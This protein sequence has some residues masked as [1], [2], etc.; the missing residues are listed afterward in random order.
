MGDMESYIVEQPR[1]AVMLSGT[2]D[3]VKKL[4]TSEYNGLFS[5]L[6][7]YNIPK[8]FNEYVTGRQQIDL[9]GDL[10]KDLQLAVLETADLW[11]GK[12]IEMKFSEEQETD[13]FDAMQDKKAMEEKYGGDIGA[14]W[15][16]MAL[17]TKR[18]AVTLAGFQGEAAGI[19]P[20]NCWR[21]AMALL[22]TLKSHC[23]QALDIIRENYGKKNISKQ[24]YDAMKNAGMTDEEIAEELGVGISTIQR[25][26][27]QW[28][29]CSNPGEQ[30]EI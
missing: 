12:I 11:N 3:Q 4:I 5:R 7:Y 13:L 9:A 19:V 18:I 14:S 15:L 16:R 30:H 10:C 28:G 17:I 24:S 2:G 22:P 21:A 27:K 8:V 29:N 6:W 26:K 23:I 20:G 25:R 1:L